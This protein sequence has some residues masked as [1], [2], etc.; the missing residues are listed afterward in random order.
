MTMLHSA[1]GVDE[2]AFR[3]DVEAIAARHPSGVVRCTFFDSSALGGRDAQSASGGVGDGGGTG[4]T[5]LGRIDEAVLRG[6]VAVSPE[7][8]VIT[9]IK[10]F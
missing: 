9:V 2:L 5:V 6:A 8:G 4:H 7:R 3:A 1:R 10:Q